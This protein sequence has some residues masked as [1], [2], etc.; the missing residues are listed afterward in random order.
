VIKDEVADVGAK[1]I[2]SH[3]AEQETIV[4]GILM[5]LA[6]RNEENVPQRLRRND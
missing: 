2:R 6:L 4:L 1:A 3:A 5:V